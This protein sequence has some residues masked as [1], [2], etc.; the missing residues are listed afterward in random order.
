MVVV[1]QTLLYDVA[2]PINP[3]LVCRGTETAMHLID[4][5]S[6]A[7]T[8]VAAGHVVILKRNLTTGAET[9]VAQLRVAPGPYYYGRVGWTWDGTT[10]VYS[11]SNVTPTST[12][13]TVTIHLWSNGADHVLYKIQAGP[14]GLESRWS[15][16]PI[17]DYSPD[18]KYVAI[19]DFGFAIYGTNI[20]IFALADLRQKLVVAA[21][22]SG[23]TWI[24]ND[25]FAW[26]DLSSSLKQ[27]TPTTGATLLR[28]DPW[29]GVTASSDGKWLAG[30][31]VTPTTGDP[32]VFIAPT[33]AGRTFQTGLASSPGFVTP[34]VV[35]YAEEK[36]DTSGG[37]T[38][39][40]PCIHPTAPDGV[41]HALDVV[42]QTDRIVHFHTGQAPKDIYGNVACCSTQY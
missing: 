32:H 24:A 1:A 40:E 2:D 23:G 21:S 16:R 41:I 11:T 18:K 30:T 3:R 35:W 22:S 29:Y 42:H 31:F 4:G 9:R 27:W 17:L 10:E 37:F 12:S 6:I 19:S 20:R 33:G 25:R 8:T 13:W 26:A 38:C 28:S 15:P 39:S 36:T 14:G 5:N 7:Y 34:T